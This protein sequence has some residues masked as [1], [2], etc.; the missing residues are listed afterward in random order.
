[1]EQ[2][3]LDEDAALKAVAQKWVGGSSPSCSAT[4]GIR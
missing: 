1:M 2:T 4:L 3:R